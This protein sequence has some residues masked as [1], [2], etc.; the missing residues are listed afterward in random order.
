MEGENK[1]GQEGHQSGSPSADKSSPSE[2]ALLTQLADQVKEL[3]RE[4]QSNADKRASVAEKSAAD[5]VERADKAEAKATEVDRLRREA[6]LEAVKDDPERYNALQIRQQA[7][8]KLVAAEKANEEA[9]RDRTL[10]K[11]EREAAETETFKTMVIQVAVDHELSI[12]ELEGDVEAL[13]LKT[14]EQIVR[15]AEKSKGPGG[16]T[17]KPDSLMGSGGKGVPTGNPRDLAVQGY[18]ESK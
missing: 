12:P 6:E 10:A 17:S 9:A 11:A 15:F 5:A 18:S 1:A 7:Q 4:N 2:E 14:K 16:S 3:A 8:E 13:G